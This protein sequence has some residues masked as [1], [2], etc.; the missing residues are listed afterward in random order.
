MNKPITVSVAVVTILLSGAI[1]E[2]DLSYNI[3]FEPPTYT[4]SDANNPD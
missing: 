3:G 1:T 4:A 2:A